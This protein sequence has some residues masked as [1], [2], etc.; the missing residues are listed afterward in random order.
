MREALELEHDR[1]KDLNNQK[2]KLFLDDVQRQLED[3]EKI[4]NRNRE[5]SEIEDEGL[6]RKAQNEE[7]DY[8]NKM[9]QKKQQMQEYLDDIMGQKEAHKMKKDLYN[10]Q[11]KQFKNTGY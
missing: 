2:R 6:N 10:E 4:K 1:L 11:E 9:F 8:R 7:A 5:L 3:K